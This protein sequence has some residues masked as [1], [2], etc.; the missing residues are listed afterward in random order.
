MLSLEVSKLQKANK[1]ESE[2]NK[3]SVNKLDTDQTRRFCLLE[4]EWVDITKCET[5][6][7][8]IDYSKKCCYNRWK[9]IPV[10]DRMD[11]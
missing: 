1:N 11:E 10:M 2:A 7:F 3:L 4:K 5:C 6:V 9:K 8:Q